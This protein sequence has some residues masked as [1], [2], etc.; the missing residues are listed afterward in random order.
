MD[1]DQNKRRRL[2][3]KGQA[4]SFNITDLSD[5]V[6]QTCLSFVGPWHYQ[7]IAGTCHRFQESHDFPERTTRESA[8]TSVSCAK[9]CVNDTLL[10]ESMG[11]GDV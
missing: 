4:S 3:P 8:G 6:L 2:N 7:F 10:N 5:V 1:S 11:L 9:F